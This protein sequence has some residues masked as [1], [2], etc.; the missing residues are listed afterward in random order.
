MFLILLCNINTFSYNITD[1]CKIYLRHIGIFLNL[2]KVLK[3]LYV[4]AVAV[5]KLEFELLMW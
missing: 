3:L 4:R 5:K 2:F 1:I